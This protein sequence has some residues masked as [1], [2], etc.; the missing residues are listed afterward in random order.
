M[1][2]EGLSIPPQP[3]PLTSVHSS[4][5]SCASFHPPDARVPFANCTDGDV[6]L[7][8]GS[9]RAEGRLEVCF[10]NA[11]GAVCGVVSSAVAQAVCRQLGLL[12]SKLCV[13]VCI[14]HRLLLKSI[15]AM[16]LPLIVVF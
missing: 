1:F 6:R 5:K 13:F 4:P 11:W 14:V 10:N 16:Q 3:P 12:Q 2:Y 15:P 7:N 8:G 9:S